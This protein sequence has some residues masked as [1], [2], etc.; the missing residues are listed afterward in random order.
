[1]KFLNNNKKYTIRHLFE[2]SIIYRLLETED[3]E[4]VG[5][6]MDIA[7]GFF[8]M[9]GA[10]VL[11]IKKEGID[12]QA[13]DEQPVYLFFLLVSP[14]EVSGPHIRALAHISRLL[15]QDAL[16]KKLINAESPQEVLDLITE[17]EKY[18]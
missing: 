8:V 11:G 10:M 12:F 17:E 5:K 16:R 14:T 18:M 13:L 4:R 1:M 6:A 7:D 15:R 9:N 2:E 3:A